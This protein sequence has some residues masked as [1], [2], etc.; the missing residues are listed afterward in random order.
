MR[1]KHK[2]VVSIA[3]KAITE[4]NA[5]VEWENIIGGHLNPKH[6]STHFFHFYFSNSRKKCTKIIALCWKT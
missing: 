1:K 6:L 4:K 2:I 5:K 3:V